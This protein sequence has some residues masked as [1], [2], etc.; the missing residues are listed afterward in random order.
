MLV[1]DQQGE[2][3]ARGRADGEG[4]W[5]LRLSSERQP[6]L[7]IAHTGGED[8]TVVGTNSAWRQG[9]GYNWSWSRYRLPPLQQL[10][11]YAYTDRPI[12]RPGQSVYF[13]VIVRQDD[14]ARYSLLPEG[15]P[16]TVTLRDGRDNLLGTFAAQTNAYGS[17]NGAFDLAEGVGPGEYDLEFEILGERQR[18]PFKVQEYRKPDFQVLLNPSATRYI[19]GDR[20]QIKVDTR[21][22]YGQPV[23]GANLTLRVYQVESNYYRWWDGQSQDSDENERYTWSSYST[24]SRPGTT[25]AD[26][27]YTFTLE[28]KIE[29]DIYR[30]WYW[31]GDSLEKS[32]YAIE[33]TADDGSNQTV[34]AYTIVHVFNAAERLKLRTDGFYHTA[35]QPF[36]LTAQVQDLDGEPVA[37][38]EMQLTLEKWSRAERDYITITETLLTSDEDGLANTTLAITQTGY[39]YLRLSSQYSYRNTIEYQ[40]GVYLLDP[41]GKDWESH[42]SSYSDSWGEFYDD[43]YLS[44]STDKQEYKP[45]ETA[46]LAIESTFSGPALLTFERSQVYRSLPVELTAPL[47]VIE[48]PILET[49]APNVFITINAWQARSSSLAEYYEQYPEEYIVF[50][51]PDSRLRLSQ[52]EVQVDASLKELEVNIASDQTIY[53]PGQPATFTVQVKDAQGEPAQAELSLA[54]VDESIYSL[55][56]ELSPPIFSAF[57][58]RREL[59]VKSFDSMAPYREIITGDRGGGGEETYPIA[60]LRTEFEDTAIW[61]PALETDENGFVTVTVTLP[62]NLTS[63]RLTA[64]AV[65][66]STRVGEGRLNIQTQ[67]EVVVDPVLPQSLVVSDEVRLAALVHNYG[68]ARLFT[69]TLAADLLEV[70]TPTQVISLSAGEGRRVEWLAAARQPGTA[71]VIVQAAPASG[72]G[73]AVQLPLRI[74][75]LVA[76]YVYNQAGS[77]RDQLTIT[78]ALPDSAL[79]SSYVHLR[80]SRS[81]S[82]S[83]LEGLEYLTGYPYGC[84]EQTMSRALP[85]AVVGRA[86]AKL[87]GDEGSLKYNLP[88]LIQ[89][90][91]ARLY[92][93]QH[94]DGGWGWWHD[95][96][97]HDYQTAWVVFGLAVTADAG[98]AVEPR[99]I[100]NGA[101]W[102]VE[103]LNE[104]DIRTR[105]YA[106]YSLATAGYAQR[107]ATLALA[108]SPQ[109]LEPFSQAALAL[110]LHEMGETGAAQK[111]LEF[112]TASAARQGEQVYWV[113]VRGDGEYDHKTMASSLRSTALALDAFVRIQPDHPLIPGIVHHVMGQRK[114]QGWGSTNETA[115]AVLALTDY[116][117]VTTVDAGLADYRIVLN[118]QQVLTGA[119]SVETN[120]VSLSI[121]IT[122]MVAGMNLLTI[123]QQGETPFYYVLTSHVDIPK[124]AVQKAGKLLVTRSYRDPKTGAALPSIT[125]GQLV[126]VAL[127]IDAPVAGSYILLEDHLPG[128]LEALNSNLN[129]TSHEALIDEEGNPYE[130]FSWEDYGYNNKE[131]RG[132]RVIFFITSLKEGRTVITYLARATQPG[133]FSALPAELSAMYDAAFWARSESAVVTVSSTLSETEGLIV[134]DAPTPGADK[135]EQP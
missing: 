91:L 97:T 44:L 95:D 9:S 37:G 77:F 93:M 13:K 110:A 68:A 79:N 129:I 126:E 112:L 19:D 30:R 81:V 116:L 61:L 34:S 40:S 74:D 48:V 76:P 92:S 46:R 101:N 57:Y 49:D 2:L 134:P 96:A 128:G 43:N 114:A 64:R 70:F 31:W 130:R 83:M 73:D 63:W 124:P 75:P 103:H 111:L 108:D 65:T 119:F 24:V 53:A 36:T 7:V 71:Q 17:L 90:G 89:D 6:A 60:G 115:F 16:V 98:Y 52:V 94:L 51:L 20:M 66:Q 88:A 32:S 58:G 86:L 109:E 1:Y 39:F 78:L 84:V 107:E 120:D 3:L 113:S 50:N 132:S 67:R 42:Y 59:G 11:I 125:A 14:D 100:E 33:V 62:D 47:T 105:A 80:L 133:V 122:Q 54:L 85:N 27:Q 55:S 22:F 18:Q 28:A 121:P 25:N 4:A 41:N 21:Y 106:L 82:G 102:L 45:Y 123:T 29:E 118:D 26:G 5:E 104:M 12:Y 38:R 23:S 99:V 135:V 127:T 72:A 10:K 56:S 117:F 15:T 8:F 87:S 35:G 131:I 69:V